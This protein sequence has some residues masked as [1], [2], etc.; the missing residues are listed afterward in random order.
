MILQE[1]ID[2]ILKGQAT[3]IDGITISEA[4]IGLFLTAVQLSD[5]SVGV[6]STVMPNDS[7][8][9][10]KKELRDFGDFS[11]L[12]IT[13]KTVTELLNF[14]TKHSLIQCLKIATLNA[15]SAKMLFSGKYKILTNIDPIDLMDIYSGK[16]ITIVGAFQSYID[17][18]SKTNSTLYVLELNEEAFLGGDRKY[19][20][21]ANEYKRVLPHSDIVLIT[22]LTLVN[23][24]LDDLLATIKPG[25]QIIVSGPSSGCMPDVMFNYNVSIIGTVKITDAE[26]MLKLASEGAAGYHMFNYCAEKICIVNE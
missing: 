10:C 15:V 8:I 19:Y 3:A 18:I 4:R 9:H 7:N 12:I 23:N 14:P 16:T 17:K 24:T 13:G 25:A 11:P 20:V 6:S 21:P 26:L 2:F 22:G 1:T 5:G